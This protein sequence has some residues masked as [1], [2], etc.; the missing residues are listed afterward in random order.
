MHTIIIIIHENFN[1]L[2]EIYINIFY[3]N[4]DSNISNYICDFRIYRK[5]CIC[6]TMDIYVFIKWVKIMLYVDMLLHIVNLIII[7]HI[8]TCFQN[9]NFNHKSTGICK[10]DICQICHKLLYYDI[11]KIL[12][13]TNMITVSNCWNFLKLFTAHDAIEWQIH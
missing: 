11:T 9:L 10:L 13:L 2:F 1:L 4:L 3:V 12:Y 8:W 5:N 7:M 6:V